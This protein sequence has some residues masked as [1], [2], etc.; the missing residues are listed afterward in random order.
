MA[1]VSRGFVGRHE[2]HD[3]GVGRLPPGQYDIGGGFPV[4]SARADPSNGDG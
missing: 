2:T 3:E 1:F 4:L